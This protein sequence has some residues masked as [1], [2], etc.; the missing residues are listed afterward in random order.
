MTRLY[1]PSPREHTVAGGGRW[2]GGICARPPRL[3]VVRDMTAHIDVVRS[4]RPRSA[5]LDEEALSR[6]TNSELDTLFRT[7]PP[8]DLPAGVLRGTVLAFPGTWLCQAIARL[9]YLV[10]WQGKVVDASRG[11]LVNRV[12]PLRLRVIKARV[13]QGL[14]WVD[15]EPCVVI[16]YSRTSVVARMVRD[17]TREVAPGLHLGVVWLRG[18]RT[19]WFALRAGSRPQG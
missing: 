9:A 17:E 11:T 16:D 8:G 13:A 2:S 12:T 1:S 18:R 10:G 14:S 6:R 4:A 15:D 19:A 5:S 7:S 3:G